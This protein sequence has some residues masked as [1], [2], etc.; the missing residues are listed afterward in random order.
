MH[1]AWFDTMVNTYLVEQGGLDLAD[2]A[3]IGLVVESGCRYAKPLAFPGDVEIGLKA[4]RP[5]TSSVR[6]EL[7]A[8]APGTAD[9]AADGFF[10]QV[11][12]DRET[13]RPVAGPPVLR[14]ALDRVG[15]DRR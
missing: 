7:G 14:R 6:Y 2:G 11:F 9:A 10:V 13:R 12:V 5:G 3:V 15:W 8:F 4:C 1:Y